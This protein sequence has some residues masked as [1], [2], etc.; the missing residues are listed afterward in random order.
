M[1]ARVPSTLKGLWL[2]STVPRCPHPRL[3]R[4]RFY[5]PV[6]HPRRRRTPCKQNYPPRAGGHF[7]HPTS[8]RP[9]PR[10]YTVSLARSARGGLA[11][12][13]NPRLE[14]PRP[15]RNCSRRGR[16]VS[17]AALLYLLPLAPRPLFLLLRLRRAR[18]FDDARPLAPNQSIQQMSRRLPRAHAS[19]R[20]LSNGKIH[21]CAA[22]FSAQSAPFETAREIEWWKLEEQRVW[23]MGENRWGEPAVWSGRGRALINALSLSFPRSGPGRGECARGRP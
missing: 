13:C 12:N 8:A 21:G 1:R 5:Y 7:T 11:Q 17:L 22:F 14:S 10:V 19:A 23:R 3:P 4:V 18:N 2:A 16:A 20:A 15:Q 9:A 6:G